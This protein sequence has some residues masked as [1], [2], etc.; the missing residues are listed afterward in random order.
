MSILGFV[1]PCEIRSTVCSV[2]LGRN[3][4]L[5]NKILVYVILLHYFRF[6]LLN[7]R[8]KWRKTEGEK[9]GDYIK[10]LPILSV[11]GGRQ[12]TK[13]TFRRMADKE[14]RNHTHVE[15]SRLSE[16]SASIKKTK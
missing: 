8:E 7:K 5:Q 1:C 9:L 12:R 10:I 6:F 16:K 2:A 11:F 3:E 4:A 14:E 13:E 15:Q